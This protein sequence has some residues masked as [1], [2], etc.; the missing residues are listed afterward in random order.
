LTGGGPFYEANIECHSEQSNSL[1]WLSYNLSQI[2]L[3][4]L[5]QQ[6]REIADFVRLARR[7]D[8]GQNAALDCLGVDLGDLASIFLGPG[9]WR[10]RRKA[11]ADC[12]KAATE[13][14]EAGAIK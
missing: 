1:A 4:L 14:K 6:H 2:L 10:P 5:R 3:N 8:A 7:E 13:E 12:W 11:I 9:D